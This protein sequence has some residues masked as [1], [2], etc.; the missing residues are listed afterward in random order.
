LDVPQEHFGHLA[1][2]NDIISK[3]LSERDEAIRLA[4]EIMERLSQLN[5]LKV[6][7]SPVIGEYYEALSD[8][9]LKVARGTSIH[10]ERN[11]AAITKRIDQR[12]WLSIMESSKLTALMNASAKNDMADSI[13][14]SPPLF[15]A[16]TVFS[17][18]DYY[19]SNRMKTFVES[20]I[21]LFE[22]LPSGYSSNDRICFRKRIVFEN[23]FRGS[24]WNGSSGKDRI[25]DLERVFMLLDGKDPTSLE[26]GDLAQN[27]MEEAYSQ[28]ER[29]INFPYF[30][31]R[32]FQNGNIHIWFSR[33]DLVEKFNG[34][35][36]T[37]YSGSLGRR[38]SKY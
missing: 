8:D 13:K 2:G 1:T 11:M 16:K 24:F 38:Y 26:F 34:M 27:R 28:G 9:V 32:M 22:S 19:L 14:L 15:E 21:S 23:A 7:Y 29:S 12:Y 30:T 6:A 10:V 20:A 36:A 4:H 17:T 5:T 33:E 25:T 31:C 37:H 35:L 18:L 3:A